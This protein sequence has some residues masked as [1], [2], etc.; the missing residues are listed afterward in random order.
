MRKMPD[1]SNAPK[2]VFVQGL[3]HGAAKAAADEHANTEKLLAE[4]SIELAVALSENER[5]EALVAQLQ[6]DNRDLLSIID[7]ITPP[8]SP[9]EPKPVIAA[10]QPPPWDL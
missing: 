2:G 5:L 8:E 7:N 4:M 10:K 6:A 3:E 1:H 9:P